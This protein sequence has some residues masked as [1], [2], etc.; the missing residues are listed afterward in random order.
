MSSIPFENLV[1]YLWDKKDTASVRKDRDSLLKYAIMAE[2]KANNDLASIIRRGD[3]D[4]VA[5]KYPAIFNEF[6]TETADLLL[7]IG[8]PAS[9]IFSENPPKEEVFKEMEQVKQPISFYNKKTASELYEFYI[10]KCNLLKSLYRSDSLGISSVKLDARCKN[11]E[12]A[13]RALIITYG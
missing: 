13:T 5:S 4:T 2:A 1:K 10:R 8:V 9:T 6:S 11:I 12:F 3:V 7:S